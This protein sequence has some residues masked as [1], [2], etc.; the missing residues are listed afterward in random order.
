MTQ[1]DK[2]AMMTTLSKGKL[3]DKTIYINFDSQAEHDNHWNTELMSVRHYFIN[4][5]TNLGS[6][7]HYNLRV[8]YNLA[9]SEPLSPHQDWANEGPPCAHLL[10]SK[11]HLR[12]SC[13]HQGW[14]RQRLYHTSDTSDSNM[15]KAGE[16]PIPSAIT[17]SSAGDSPSP[18]S[19]TVRLTPN[20]EVHLYPA[21]QLPPKF[22]QTR[23]QENRCLHT[24]RQEYT[25]PTLKDDLPA[26]IP[27]SPIDEFEKEDADIS[28]A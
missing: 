28:D 11:S 2:E 22:Y 26:T 5:L 20:H 1:F 9:T 21:F 16:S 13:K 4:L 24:A 15:S 27:I 19:T 12:W 10:Y 14:K 23:A 3:G 8:I 6:F 25:R 18:N 17:C 7:Q